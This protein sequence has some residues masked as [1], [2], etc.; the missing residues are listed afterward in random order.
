MVCGRA[1][2]VLA[3]PAVVPVS[4]NPTLNE[5]SL[6]ALM[7]LLAIGTFLALRRQRR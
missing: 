1:F 3:G 4:G 2:V 5:W 6:I 7:G